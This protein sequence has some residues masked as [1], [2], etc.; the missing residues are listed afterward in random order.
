[1]IGINYQRADTNDFT[2]SDRTECNKYFPTLKLLDAAQP[3]DFP[4]VTASDSN[5]IMERYGTLAGGNLY[6]VIFNNSGLTDH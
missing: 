1:M 2:E 4:H 6:F 5:L 3:Q